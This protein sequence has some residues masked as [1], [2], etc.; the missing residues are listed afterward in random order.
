MKITKVETV[1]LVCPTAKPYYNALGKSTARCCLMVRI[2][3]DEGIVGI[4][5]AAYFGG[6]LISTATV[7]EKELGPKLIGE[8]P[9]NVEYIWHKLFY[10]GFQHARNGIFVCALSGIDIA[11]WDIVGK[12]LKQPIY[13]LLGGYTNKVKV[14]ASGGFYGL[15][16]DKHGVAAELKSYVD[17]GFDTVKMKVGR[18]Y[19]PMTPRELSNAAD[20][21]TISLEEDMERVRTVRERI[22]DGVKLMVDANT[23]WNYSDA[24]RAGRYFD[25]LNVYLFEEPLC[26]DDYEGSA[27]LTAQ[28]NTRI[29]GYESECLLKNFARMIA[30][31]CVDVVQPDVSWAGGFTECRKIAA[32]AQAHGV[33]CAPHAFSSGILLAASLHFAAG[34]ANGGMV[35]FDM[36]ENPLRSELLKKPFCQEHSYITLPEDCFGLGI[37]LDEEVVERY[38]IELF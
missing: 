19:T 3:T 13:R 38:R 6:P 28:L 7:I 21:C 26:T 18:T 14:Y 17:A 33:E 23:A 4:G 2:Y 30:N 5:E 32:V 36:T 35:E 22:G 27:R 37:E 12:S 16:K 34:F 15:D 11:L 25:E 9:L 10:E 20:E 24:L 1:G 29:A 8:N 31:R